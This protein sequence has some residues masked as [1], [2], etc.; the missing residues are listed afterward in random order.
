MNH[1]SLL[2]AISLPYTLKLFTEVMTLKSL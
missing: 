1:S 2:L